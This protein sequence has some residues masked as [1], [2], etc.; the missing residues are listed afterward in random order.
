MSL[1][2]VVIFTSEMFFD[3][4]AVVYFYN[5]PKGEHHKVKNPSKLQLSPSIHKWKILFCCYKSQCCISNLTKLIKG[6]FSVVALKNQKRLFQG[7]SIVLIKGIIFVPLMNISH[8]QQKQI[9]LSEAPTSQ[10]NWLQHL[11]LCPFC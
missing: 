9:H 10:W 6:K 1:H 5:V 3:P 11:F 4:H 8:A 7:V 2:L